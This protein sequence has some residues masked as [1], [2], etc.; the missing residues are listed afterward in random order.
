MLANRRHNG[1]RVIG[2]GSV[3]VECN[4]GLPALSASDRIDDR[5][6][7][8]IDKD[9]VVV[10]VL[11][12]EHPVHDVERELTLVLG[13]C[14]GD[15]AQVFHRV[16]REVVRPVDVGDTLDV[17]IRERIDRPDSLRIVDRRENNGNC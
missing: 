17:G 16:V 2:A 4:V 1:K 8:L 5:A 15:P 10:F 13:F 7:V 6:R 9:V 11:V 12:A 3:K 14:A